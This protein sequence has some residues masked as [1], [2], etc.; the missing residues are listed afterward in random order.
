MVKVHLATQLLHKQPTQIT[1]NKI[2]IQFKRNM[3]IKTQT[4]RRQTLF[5]SWTGEK[6]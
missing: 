6:Q 2:M 5:T 3:I 1:R 4:G